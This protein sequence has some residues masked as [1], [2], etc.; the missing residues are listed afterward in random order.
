MCPYKHFPAGTEKKSL[1]KKKKKVK[2][3]KE[4]EKG[5]KEKKVVLIFESYS[6][7]FF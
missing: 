2:K 6:S 1:K 5:E 4:K 7:F 3:R